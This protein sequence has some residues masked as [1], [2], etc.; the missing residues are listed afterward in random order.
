VAKMLIKYG[1]YMRTCNDKIGLEGEFIRIASRTLE[2]ND[3]VLKSICDV[4][5]E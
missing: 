5:K 2:E 1:I 4:F 3:M